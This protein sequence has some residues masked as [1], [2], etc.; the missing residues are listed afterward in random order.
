MVNPSDRHDAASRPDDRGPSPAI[1]VCVSLKNRS[2]VEHEGRDLALFPNCVHCLADAASNLRD[3]GSIELVVADFYS[4]DWPLA[5]WLTAAAGELQVRVIPIEGA[6]SRGRGLNQ[7]VAQAASD[8]LLL[9]DADILIKPAALRR[10]LEILDQGQVWLPI[11]RYLDQ[12]GRLEFW[13]EFGYGIAAIQRSTFDAVRG[14]PEFYSWGGEDDLFLERLALHVPI[15]REQTEGL[16]HQWHPR[17]VRFV[18]YSRPIKSDFRQHL[19]T[20]ARTSRWG[21]PVRR[22]LGEHPDWRGELH[23][24]DNG[25]LSRPGIDSGDFVLEERRQIVLKWDRWPAMTLHW[26]EEDQVYR[27]GSTLFTLQEITPE[28]PDGVPER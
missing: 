26:N 4:D 1:S 22:F 21:P 7:A 23:F 15:V 3:V 14:I 20:A 8:R 25:R 12:E 9:C 10:A 19:A 6:F 11:C 18:H 16:D 27:D 28:G 24:F 5:A 2:R 17:D 13:Q